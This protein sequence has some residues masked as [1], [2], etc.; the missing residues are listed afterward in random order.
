M[1]I[2]H[3]A[4]IQSHTEEWKKKLD[5]TDEDLLERAI[6]DFSDRF[7]L[8]SK[9]I[10]VPFELSLEIPFRKITVPKIGDKKHIVDLSLKILEFI[11]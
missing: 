2:Y 4:I 1:K 3:G 5:E 8:T 7:N 6:I 10:Y 11:V 9:E